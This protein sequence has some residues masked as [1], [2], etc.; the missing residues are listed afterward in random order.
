[1]LLLDLFD[2]FTF[3]FVIFLV[4]LLM[5]LQ[6]PLFLNLLKLK[7]ALLQKSSVDDLINFLLL[8]FTLLV[9]FEHSLLSFA[10]VLEFPIVYIIVLFLL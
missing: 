4:I 2:I 1:M 9:E 6:S 7:T 10:F 5:L 3:L 8:F